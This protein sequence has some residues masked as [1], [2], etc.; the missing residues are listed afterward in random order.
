MKQNGTQ[1]WHDITKNKH[2][3]EINSH[4]YK[5]V[6]ENKMFRALDAI[7]EQDSEGT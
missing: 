2:P 5:V 6:S 3:I 7:L 1:S 4:K